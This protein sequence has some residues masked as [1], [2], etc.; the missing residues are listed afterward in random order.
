MWTESKKFEV[1]NGVHAAIMWYCG[2]LETIIFLTKLHG[3]ERPFQGKRKREAD[4]NGGCHG[5]SSSGASFV[6]MAGSWVNLKKL[7]WAHLVLAHDAQSVVNNEWKFMPDELV[8]SLQRNS[9][10]LVEEQ[11]PKGGR[12]LM[13]SSWLVVKVWFPAKCKL[14]CMLH[15]V[16]WGGLAVW[17]CL[18]VVCVG[19]KSWCSVLLC[20]LNSD[21]KPVVSFLVNG[22][23][24]GALFL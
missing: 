12:Y 4:D 3:L 15:S 20:P 11:C 8:V 5:A 18:R 2:S 10:T 14:P 23:G 1:E 24:A 6:I 17:A 19:G 22:A 16:F 13:M 21:C 7:T 9:L